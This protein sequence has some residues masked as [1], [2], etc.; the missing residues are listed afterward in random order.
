MEGI[1]KRR[2]IWPAVHAPPAAF[3]GLWLP[4]SCTISSLRTRPVSGLAVP[5]ASPSH[6]YSQW[7]MTR[8][9]LLT[10]AGAA[11][12]LHLFPVYPGVNARHL[13]ARAL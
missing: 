1:K 2:A 4:V 7:P 5:N 3:P 9:Y 13:E 12:A 10:V 11:Q 8:S 6:D